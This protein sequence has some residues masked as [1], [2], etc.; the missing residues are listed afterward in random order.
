MKKKIIFV[1]DTFFTKRDF[2]RLGIFFIKKKFQVQFISFIKV[3]NHKFY[4]SN[5]KN[6][7][8]KLNSIMNLNVSNL[9]KFLEKNKNIKLVVNFL[10]PNKKSQSIINIF[11]KKKIK[12]LQFKIGSIP[13]SSN[14]VTSKKLLKKLQIIKIVKKYYN[15]I[16]FIL[17]R[18]KFFRLIDYCIVGGLISE[19]EINCA[20][21]YGHSH[22]Y[23][24]YL[25]TLKMHTSIKKDYAVFIDEMMPDAPD[26]N[27]FNIKKP[28]DF[29]LYWTEIAKVLSEI[30]KFLNL[31]IIIALHP[32]NIKNQFI[33]RFD[34]KHGLTPLLI[35]NSKLVL[36]HT[37]TAINYAI[38]NRKPM[39]FINSNNYSW[40]EYR[41]HNF[42][43]ET[44]G[45]ILYINK[46]I[47]S[48]IDLKRIYK[49]NKKKYE[50]YLD[51]YIKHPLSKNL[52][53]GEIVTKLALNLV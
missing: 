10:T 38:I 14:F 34:C 29:K 23:E 1:T 7:K 48:Q 25:D 20:K 52:R 19:K 22:D 21:L 24:T 31:K 53:L 2:Q 30:E 32:K 45:Q 39:L 16:N 47:K 5:K 49:I 44:D 50:I 17:E 28:L 42:Q 41:I 11:K 18:K 27:L 43:K 46:D 36:L 35:K 8:N 15:Y 3:L 9:N 4:L 13:N 6:Y 40:Q 51:N 26:Y 12:I 37:S 33:K